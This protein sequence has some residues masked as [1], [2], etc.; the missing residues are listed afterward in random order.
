V[1]DGALSLDTLRTLSDDDLLRRLNDL[2]AQSRRVE[3]QLVAHIGEVDER[4]LYAREGCDTVFV[5]CTEVLHLSEHEAYLRIAAGRAARAH[6]MLLMMLADGRIH[7]S[8]IG[9]RVQFTA[10]RGLYDKI[11]RLKA[12]MDSA[13]RTRRRRGLGT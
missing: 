8:G 7:L 13:R 1:S 11:E 4:R 2:L 10:T 5:Y 3:W 9:N 6:P 12:V